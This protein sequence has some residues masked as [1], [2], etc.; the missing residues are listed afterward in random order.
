MQLLQLLSKTKVSTLQ[1][2]EAFFL[3]LWN[4]MTHEQSLDSY[5][6]RCLNAHSVVRELAE[7]LRIGRISAEQL[8]PLCAETLDIIK[9]DPVLP[10]CLPHHLAITADLLKEASSQLK[11]DD[12]GK[13]RQWRSELGYAVEDF[14][15]AVDR[16]YFSKLLEELPNALAS[17]DQGQIFAV[18]GTLLSELVDRGWPLEPLFSWV[19]LFFQKKADHHATFNGNLRFLISQLGWEPQK[20]RVVLKFVGSTELASFGCFS[21]FSFRADAGFKPANANQLNFAAQ[22]AQVSFGETEI[23]AFDFYS[24]AVKGREKFESCLDQLRFN[25]ESASIKVDQRCLV[26]RADHIIRFPV[27]RHLVPNPDQRL[28]FAAFREFSQRLHDTLSRPSL[29]PETGERLSAAIRHYRLGSDAESYK[30]KFLNWWMG[31]EYLT[32]VGGSQKLGVEVIES[33][34]AVLLQRYLYRL[35]VDLLNTIKPDAIAWGPEL[36]AESGCGDLKALEANQLLKVL[37]SAKHSA[38]L[39]GS[40]P[41]NPVTAF[42]VN[43]LASAL[44]TPAKSADLLER[45]ADHLRWQLARLYRI[46]CCIVHGSPLRFKLPLYAA[47]LEFYLREAIIT[48]L[49]TFGMNLHV[50]SLKDV[51]QRAAFS[52]K[53]T[54]SNL[55][56]PTASP[57][58]VRHAVFNNVV[59]QEG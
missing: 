10:H 45:H 12:E 27:V 44:Q 32:R 37:Q 21:G 43:R 13:A 11:K 49:P 5:R 57:D 41:Q 50:S 58:D 34:T 1:P 52:R 17:K 2:H 20:F 15:T 47:N 53:R 6:V 4:E 8:K 48:I 30:D 51:Y 42:R 9:A 14:L 23:Y 26:E 25:F 31:L 59:I 16:T 33:T 19:R 3:E 55:K 18:T 54:L 56:A 40:F 28:S 36:V 29:D 38:I 22:A 35:V 7:E 46:R 39:A 24:A